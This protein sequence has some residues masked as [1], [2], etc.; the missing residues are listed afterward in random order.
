VI[1]A[2]RRSAARR[3]GHRHHRRTY[4]PPG[5][6]I[7]ALREYA[8]AFDAVLVDLPVAARLDAPRRGELRLALAAV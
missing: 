8:P 3:T 7:D 6:G 2:A 4:R 1:T 5:T